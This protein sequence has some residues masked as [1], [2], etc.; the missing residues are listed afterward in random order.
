MS[1]K[2]PFA[3]SISPKIWKESKMQSN[4]LEKNANDIKGLKSKYRRESCIFFILLFD[5]ISK[6]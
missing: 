5:E 1:P 6:N 4:I 3:N 2:F